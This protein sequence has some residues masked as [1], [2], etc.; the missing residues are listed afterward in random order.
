MFSSKSLL[1]PASLVDINNVSYVF[2]TSKA[3][4]TEVAATALARR[5]HRRNWWRFTSERTRKESACTG[6]IGTGKERRFREK[7]VLSDTEER[8][9]QAVYDLIARVYISR[10]KIE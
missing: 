4:T 8:S 6:T 9:T 10:N 5:D 1:A 7:V 3:S 2:T